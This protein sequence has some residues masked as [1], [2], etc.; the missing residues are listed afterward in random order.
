MTTTTLSGF[1]LKYSENTREEIG[2]PIYV[3]PVS[4]SLTYQDS[5]TVTY[6]QGVTEP[7]GILNV[8]EV[9]FSFSGGYL[10]ANRSLDPQGTVAKLTFSNGSFATIVSVYN[11]AED[12]D[13]IFLLDSSPGFTAPTNQ[14]SLE[15]LL[16]NILS[17][18]L[19]TGKFAPN[20]EFSLYD[21][22][23]GVST[24]DDIFEGDNGS[25]T[26]NAGTGNDIIYGRDGDDTLY[27]GDGD[28]KI[29]GGAG[30]DV[31]DGGEGDDEIYG[32]YGDDTLYASLDADIEDGGEGI[33]TYI[34]RETLGYVPVIDLKL[35]TAY[36]QGSLPDY[37][38]SVT[39]IENV[40]MLG[41][42]AISIIG[43][44]VNNILNGGSSDDTLEG[45]AGDDKLDGGA[46][47]DTL[48]GGVG[49]DTLIGGDGRDH[50]YGGSGDDYINPGDNTDWDYVE[51]GGGNDTIDLSDIQ[52][53][54]VHLSYA[55]LSSA[56]VVDID[57]EASLGDITKNTIGSDT[58]NAIENAL[59]ADG[60]G[61]VGTTFND[62][63]D[64]FVAK[65]QWMQIRAGDGVD[66]Y[67]LGGEGKVRLDLQDGQEGISVDLTAR[68]IKNDGFG[69]S[70]TYTGDFS[71][72]R[73][74]HHDD[75]IIGS[76]SKNHE[77]FV[78][79][80][81]NDMLDGSGLFDTVSYDRLGDIQN[82]EVDLSL[83]LAT[84]TW[85]GITFK[86]QLLNIEEVFGSS[87][88]D[89]I[90]GSN[91]ADFLDGR[92]GNDTLT[93]GEGSDTFIFRGTF[94]H[95][96]ITD[97]DED[98][99]SLEFCEDNGSVILTSDL[100]ESTDADG[101]RVLS[102]S[103]GLSSV[104]FSGQSITPPSL[105][106]FDI[107]LTSESN[108]TA[109]FEIYADA[110]V[111]PDNDGI[112]SFEFTLSH[113]PSDLLIDID[114]FAAASGI[115]GVPNYDATTGTLEAAAFA[116]P[117]FDGPHQADCCVLSD[118]P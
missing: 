67:S 28:D 35:E 59:Y 30:D 1:S 14:A 92:A 91:N 44:D 56:I 46:G 31:L 34:I 54:Y 4:V 77:Y 10:E 8:P 40:Q 6:G 102:T 36:L 118:D 64:V 61:L 108:G 70:E 47:D 88:E 104:T 63:F 98:N 65:D 99:D 58:I 78:L 62:R 50:L 81:G 5:V 76:S 74:T 110:S 80:G 109:T 38:N 45:G 71:G 94:D 68:S 20:T 3:E 18:Q 86:H 29:E 107:A 7:K 85:D 9:A 32:G 97:F 33:D 42:S 53:G 21:I 52:T 117:N 27:G 51:G 87:N 82:L 106:A 66:T 15:Y 25:D 101:N 95:D 111:D 100:V 12:Q 73:G 105:P 75:V 69:N 24:E 22:P 83:G 16:D 37:S 11:S 112:G 17:V 79:R 43:S 2:V 89:L 41:D 57:G 55:M 72:V 113:D 60:L 84:G 13:Y 116:F 96:I 39:N 19:L 115:S 23:A 93:G 26:I 49:D 48:I 114:S 103:D 90:T